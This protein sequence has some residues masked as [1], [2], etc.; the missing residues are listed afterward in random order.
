MVQCQ[1][2]IQPISRDYI[3]GN[4]M[5]VVRCTGPHP[6]TILGKVD[7]A[8]NLRIRTRS[9]VGSGEI[10]LERGSVICGGC[11]N[12]MSWNSLGEQ[13]DIIEQET[14]NELLIGAK[15]NNGSSTGGDLQNAS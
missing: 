10:I 12:K 15:S 2:C 1:V 5:T 11:G 3:M 6:P 13:A 4:E 14:D 7:K 8:G 9:N